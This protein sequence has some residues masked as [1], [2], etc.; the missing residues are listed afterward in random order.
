MMTDYL[1]GR[2][3]KFLPLMAILFCFGTANAQF[4]IEVKKHSNSIYIYES[5][6]AYQGGKV[7]A[8][9]VIF[10][11]K[12]SVVVI[13][14]PWGDDQTIQLLDWIDR[15]IK[16]P[17]ASFVVTHFHDDRI[18]GI[19]ILKQRGIPA[20]SSELTAKLAV[21]NGIVKPDV[22]FKNDTTIALAGGK[23][24]VFYPGAGHSPDNVV[25][26]FPSEKLLYGGC[27][28]KD[29]STTSLGNLGDADVAAWP[30]SLEKMKKRFPKPKMVIPG[31]GGLEPGAIENTA[32]L[33]KDKKD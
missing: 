20:V 4:Q 3:K 7:G 16:K 1:A 29:A 2:I 26:Y 21:E 30:V 9:A 6:G 10:V 33:L 27:F 24:E 19:D 25:V 23:I 13:D 32:K 31:H 12:D 18:G 15:E 11:G 17:V 5:Y 14:T 28:L 8:N 22:L